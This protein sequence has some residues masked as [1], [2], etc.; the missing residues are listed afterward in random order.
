M[1]VKLVKGLE[2]ECYRFFSDKLKKQGFVELKLDA[3]THHE[4][5]LA[6]LEKSLARVK[7][8]TED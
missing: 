4:D 2:N 5:R 1:R 6:K 8:A 3:H 7:K